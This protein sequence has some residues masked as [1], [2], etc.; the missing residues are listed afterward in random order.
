MRFLIALIL[1]C[2]FLS[3]EVFEILVQNCQQLENNLKEIY[4]KSYEMREC[5]LKITYVEMPGC[6]ESVQSIIDYLRESDWEI[7]KYKLI[8]KAQDKFLNQ[9]R[10]RLDCVFGCES[11]E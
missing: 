10:W 9:N 1:N 3:A 11:S 2:S 7:L 8:T 5:Y 4:S 6:K